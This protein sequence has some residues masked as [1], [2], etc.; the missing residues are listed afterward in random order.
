[1]RGE[2]KKAYPCNRVPGAI[3]ELCQRIGVEIEDNDKGVLLLKIRLRKSGRK[4]GG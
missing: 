1:V 4:V 3:A 2:R